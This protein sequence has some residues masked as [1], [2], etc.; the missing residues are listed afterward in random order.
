ML[1]W[2]RRTVEAIRAAEAMPSIEELLTEGV[3]YRDGQ[4][5]GLRV[6]LREA[7]QANAALQVSLANAHH[8]QDELLAVA[9]RQKDQL[10][11]ARR[12]TAHTG[13]TERILKTFLTSFSALV[14]DGQRLIEDS[15]KAKS[16]Q[17]HEQ[18]A[19]GPGVSSRVCG[20]TVPIRT[21]AG[22]YR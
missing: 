22:D 19:Q 2:E 21:A 12:I 14:E 17:C 20:S 9:N 8:H 16:A 7:R 4:I 5:K 6:E 3:R 1:G 15:Q 18:P 13:N 11:Q 10:D